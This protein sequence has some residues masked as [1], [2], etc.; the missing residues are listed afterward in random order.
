LRKRV[1]TAVTA[2]GQSLTAIAKTSRSAIQPATTG[3]AAATKTAAPTR[4]PGPVAADWCAPGELG[5]LLRRCMPTW[6]RCPA[7]AGPAP[8]I[9]SPPVRFEMGLPKPPAVSKTH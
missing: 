6:A 3:C 7:P 9:S 2:G 8:S 4:G 5:A 1:I